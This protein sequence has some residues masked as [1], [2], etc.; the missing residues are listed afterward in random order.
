LHGCREKA[1]LPEDLYAPR[2]LAALAELREFLRQQHD[3]NRVNRFLAAFLRES[4]SRNT[5]VTA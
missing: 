4:P 1:D 2:D 5:V 3:R